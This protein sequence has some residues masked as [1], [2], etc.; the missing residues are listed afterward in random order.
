M[1]KYLFILSV[2]VVGLASCS[3]DK[4]PVQPVVDPTVQAKADDDAIVAYLTAH[5]SILASKDATTGLYYQVL[6]PGT[7]AAITDNSTLVV[8]YAS[9]NLKDVQIE[10][11]DN[12]SFKLSTLIPGW[13]IGLP[14]I[15][16]GGKIILLIPSALAYGP[17]G[18]GAIPP[19]TVIIF[20]I[21]VKSVDGVL[22]VD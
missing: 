12:V 5:P 7:G 13:R 6:Q 17:Y 2:L 19:N 14:K 16:N 21:T 1:K 11:N 3:K 9:K 10:A 4:T 18:S 22:P 15:K 8:N 20:T